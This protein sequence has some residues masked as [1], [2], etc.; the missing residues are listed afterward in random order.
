VETRAIGAANTALHVLGGIAGLY[1]RNSQPLRAA[2]LLGLVLCH[3]AKNAELERESAPLLEE[4][5]ATLPADELE[6]ALERGGKR[7]LETVV[8]ELLSGE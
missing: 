3:T 7:A 4:L 5:R 6:A 8:D 1:I 2:E